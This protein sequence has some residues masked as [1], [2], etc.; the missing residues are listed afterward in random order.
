MFGG[1]K[2]YL[3]IDFN[4]RKY[5]IWF[6]FLQVIKFERNSQLLLKIIIEIRIFV[7]IEHRKSKF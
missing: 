4:K 1:I 3:K 6:Q 7:Q 2:I 5:L